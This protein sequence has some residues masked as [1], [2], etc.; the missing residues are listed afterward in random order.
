MGMD[1]KVIMS[2]LTITISTKFQIMP[3]HYTE[4]LREIQKLS[5]EVRKE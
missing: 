3:Y 4:L 2:F 1:N 5:R